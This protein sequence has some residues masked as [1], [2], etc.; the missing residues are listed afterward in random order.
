M[1]EAAEQEYP[2]AQNNLAY[3]YANG[4]GVETNFVEAMTWWSLAAAQSNEPAM[5][6]VK[7]LQPKM[8]DKELRQAK[9]KVKAFHPADATK[10]Q[11]P[12]H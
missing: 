12:I 6:S 7:I 8:T 3:M 11:N 2:A 4:K 9:Q 5:I 10:Q 1:L